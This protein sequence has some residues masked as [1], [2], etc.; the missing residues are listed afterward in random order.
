[1]ARKIPKKPTAWHDWRD[2]N[3]PV[4]I[5]YVDLDS[6]GNEVGPTKWADIPPEEMSEIARE[7]FLNSIEPTWQYDPTYDLVKR[8]RRR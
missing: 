7:S 6:W 4:V 2:S 1:M 5:A 3:M 8:K